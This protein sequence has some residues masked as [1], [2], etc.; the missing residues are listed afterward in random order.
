MKRLKKL[1]DNALLACIAFLMNRLS[2]EAAE[3]LAEFLLRS[4]GY[5]VISINDT[6]VNDLKEIQNAKHQTN[7]H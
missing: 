2:N 5:S 3:Y 7:Y 6:D 4:L 1:K